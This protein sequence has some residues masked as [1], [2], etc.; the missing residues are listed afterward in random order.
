[1]VPLWARSWRHMWEFDY[2]SG[3]GVRMPCGVCVAAGAAAF[4]DCLCVSDGRSGHNKRDRQERELFAGMVRTET[5][6][7]ETSAS[8]M[9]TTDDDDGA[10][11]MS[12]STEPEGE[13]LLSITSQSTS[14]STASARVNAPIVDAPCSGA[15]PTPHTTNPFAG[16]ARS[17]RIPGKGA[18]RAYNVDWHGIVCVVFAIEGIVCVCR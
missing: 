16:A 7:S 11:A 9:S 5:C 17:I 2:D 15:S 18:L 13:Q 3:F 4:G 14:Q 1:M 10:S 6:K 8:S 12:M